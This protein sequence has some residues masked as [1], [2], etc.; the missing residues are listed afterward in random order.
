MQDHN[1]Y[2]YITTNKNK[3]VLYTGFTGNL[4]Q[5]VIQH[6]MA[7]TGAADKQAFTYRYN[8]PFIVY[9][10]H[11]R[12]VQAAIAR[13]KQLKGWTRAKKEALI[14]ALNPEWRFLNDELKW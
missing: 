5:R 2:V 9:Y 11:F 7:Q 10:E 6:E 1:Y 4:K 3:T 13:E 8:A 14:Q 12:D